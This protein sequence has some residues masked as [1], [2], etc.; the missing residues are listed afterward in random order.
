V[1]AETGIGF[2]CEES[3][4]ALCVER[5]ASVSEIVV[6][7]TEARSVISDSMAA[8]GGVMLGSSRRRVV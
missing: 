7:G 1:P 2:F 8:M 3:S 4:F 6:S 5:R